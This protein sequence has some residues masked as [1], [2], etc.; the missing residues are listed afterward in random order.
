MD[1]SVT[2][3]KDTI[4][5]YPYALPD[6]F[7]LKA[8][9]TPVVIASEISCS[10]EVFQ[11]YLLNGREQV[12]DSIAAA[13]LGV[14]NTFANVIVPPGELW[15][16]WNFHLQS[17]IPAASSIRMRNAVRFASP[18]AAPYGPSS[19][20]VALEQIWTD[21]AAGYFVAAGGQFFAFVEALVGAAV[22]LNAQITF[23]RLR[24]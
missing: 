22:P 13:A 21:S 20:G 9:S 11:L 12:S 10:V 7:G 4:Q 24:V 23:T 16:V 15:Y 14:G 6:F 2:R 1:P 18:G 5:R 17:T 19:S 3:Q 8:G